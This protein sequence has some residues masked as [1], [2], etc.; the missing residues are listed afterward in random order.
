MRG[1]LGRLVAEGA[2]GAGKRGLRGGMAALGLVLERHRG[3]PRDC[4][5]V[6]HE[7]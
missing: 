3:D 6:K 4:S 7:C 2:G 1:D 5:L